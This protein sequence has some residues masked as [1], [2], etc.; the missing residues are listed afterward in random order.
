MNAA[1]STVDTGCRGKEDR[2]IKFWQR[3]M[4]YVST[5]GASEQTPN[6]CVIQGEKNKMTNKYSPKFR[7]RLFGM[8]RTFS[9]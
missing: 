5:A 6:P 4:S 3:R 1:F 2:L 7:K 9:K 8:Y